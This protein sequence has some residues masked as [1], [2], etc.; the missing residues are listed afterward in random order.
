MEES[1]ML[2]ENFQR[3]G[4][5]GFKPQNTI[6][7]GWVGGGGIMD[8]FCNKKTK[9]VW[10]HI[11]C[12]NQRSILSIKLFIGRLEGPLFEAAQCKL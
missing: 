2:N 10:R 12:G 7:W 5:K 9:K 6:H 1:M 11:W 4:W 8:I 3:D